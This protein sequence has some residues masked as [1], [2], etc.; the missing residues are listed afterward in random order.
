MSSIRR[1]AGSGG[2]SIYGNTSVTSLGNGASIDGRVPASLEVY[3]DT[4]DVPHRRVG[5]RDIATGDNVDASGAGA[6]HQ[7]PPKSVNLA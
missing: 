2:G 7:H 6:L 4:S 3:A 1:D 5:D